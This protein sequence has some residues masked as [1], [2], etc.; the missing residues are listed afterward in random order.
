MIPTPE[1]MFG[2]AYAWLTNVDPAVVTEAQYY[3]AL[4]NYID[5]AIAQGV[6]DDQFLDEHKYFKPG[7][8]QLYES[9]RSSWS[10]VPKA[11]HCPTLADMLQG[12]RIV[13]APLSF[14]ASLKAQ[15]G[16]FRE[17]CAKAGKDPDNLDETPDERAKR[18]SRERM[19]RKR[20]RDAETDC[21]DE[22][23]V[24]LLR[25]VRA[26]KENAK[27]GNTWFKGV[28][29]TA[30]TAYDAAVDRAKLARTQTVSAARVHVI[31]ADTAVSEA[32][33]ALSEYRLSK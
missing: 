28:E 6:P 9:V 14:E 33:R 12:V 26:A 21:Q 15:Y 24:A 18:K 5:H 10:P 16:R 8:L 13:G 11:R 1:S 19:R 32:E 2:P 23:E 4:R 29:A 30:K 27:A 20:S 31:A 3:S 17:W 7:D 25:A 22:S